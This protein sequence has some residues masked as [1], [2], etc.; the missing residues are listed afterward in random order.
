MERPLRRA[1]ERKPGLRA[2]RRRRAALTGLVLAAS[3]PVG[4]VPDG[5]RQYVRNGFKVGPEYCKP[6]APVAAT[7]I[8]ADDPR[9]YGPSPQDGAWWRAFQDPVL[10][11]LVAVAY[12]DNPDLRSV[13]TRV[14]QAR[15]QQAI[16]VGN[17]FPQTQQFLGLAPYGNLGDTPAHLEIA[18]FNLNWE[19]DFWGRYR[20]QVESA[21]A[22]LDASVENYD[23]ALVTLLADVA[24]SY[25]Q[26]RV[27]Q[28]RIA[29]ALENLRLQEE[30]VAVA[31][32]QEQVGTATTLDVEQLRTLMEQTRSS[33]PAL[34]IVRGLANDQLCVLLGEP[35]H[36]LE[37]A[38]GPGP[39]P[40]T[41]PMPMIPTSV[42]AG[43][44]AD[45][46][47][48]RPDVRGAE[49]LVAAQSAQIGVAESELYP[50][51]SIGTLL[52][53]QDIGLARTPLRFSGGL[54]FVVPQISWNILNYGRLVNNV[55]LQDARTQELIAAY[56][57]AVLTAAREVQSALR[58]FLR[59]QEQA[60]ALARSAAAAVSATAIEQRNFTQIRADVNRLF[61]L[62]NA[63]LQAQ[64]QH[65][66]AQGNVALDLIQVYR[67]LGG[68]WELRLRGAHVPE[69]PIVGTTA[70]AVPGGPPPT[71]GP[72]APPRE[73]PA[74][75]AA[76][77]GLPE[78]L[79]M[80]DPA[81]AGARVSRAGGA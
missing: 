1:H 70:P 73:G 30:L 65:A 10:D 21:N 64:D 53:Q 50:H 74:A 60:D 61:N 39:G 52:G 9:V 44:P 26:Y 35:P 42:A 72:F 80:R 25:V 34:E 22:S 78:A 33:I 13:G 51:I 63:R 36:D 32:R 77:G 16:A 67:A 54:A 12:R 47:R 24:T 79:P 69:A 62:A 6:P 8:Q 4:C 81:P 14:L 48:R 23:A 75:P 46:L 20:R 2:R 3:L 66:V 49:R 11:A 19:L 27:A 45:L 57:S 15:A 38:L 56:Q 43:I 31:E 18:A 76:P 37:P 71:V 7:W 68:G 29:I 40:S 55:R 28:Q 41:L 58:G 17:F 59:S 5:L